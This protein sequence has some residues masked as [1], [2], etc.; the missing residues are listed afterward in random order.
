MRLF[1]KTSLSQKT[2]L[3]NPEKIR[4]RGRA[5]QGTKEEEEEE[6]KNEED[7]EGAKNRTHTA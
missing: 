2:E 4:L 7:E 5:G 6:E 3:A 1:L